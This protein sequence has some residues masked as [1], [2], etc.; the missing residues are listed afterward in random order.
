MIWQFHNMYSSAEHYNFKN[1]TF[2][3][4]VLKKSSKQSSLELINNHSIWVSQL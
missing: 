3:R 4:N 2:L 1:N